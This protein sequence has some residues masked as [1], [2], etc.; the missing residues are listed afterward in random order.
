MRKDHVKKFRWSFCIYSQASVSKYTY[1][2]MKITT[3]YDIDHDK[4]DK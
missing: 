2:T 1:T 4:Q 3:Y